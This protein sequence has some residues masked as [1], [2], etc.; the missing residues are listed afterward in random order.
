[1]LYEKIYAIILAAGKGKR[2]KSELPKVLHKLRGQAL[3]NWVLDTV[4]DLSVERTIVVVG[5]GR[6]LVLEHIHCYYDIEKVQFA[7]QEEMLGTA[8]AVKQALPLLPD[9]GTVLVLCGDVPFLTSRTLSRLLICHR[10]TGAAA[11]LLTAMAEVPTGYG[12][13]VRSSDDGSVLRVV[14]QQDASVEET[15]IRE[16]NSG[17][18]VFELFPL[19]EAISLVKNVNA[20]SE[21]YLTDVIHILRRQGNRIS[22]LVA[23]SPWEVEGINSSE[24]LEALNQKFKRWYS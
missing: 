24:Q 6:D 1:M 8:D 4:I 11:T 18:Y 19:R 5:F 20:Q 15:A 23:E 16:I 7:V 2:M 10:D 22:A 21:Y 9:S 17:T 3:I 14:E 12:R 13:V